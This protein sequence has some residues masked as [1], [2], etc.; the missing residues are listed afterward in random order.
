MFKPYF[1]C[2][3]QRLL[4]FYRI[5]ENDCASNSAGLYGAASR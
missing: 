3:R 5:A 2:E 1:K 4:Q